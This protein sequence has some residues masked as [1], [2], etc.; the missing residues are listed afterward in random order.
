MKLSKYSNVSVYIAQWKLEVTSLRD[1]SGAEDRCISYTV[2][3]DPHS[4]FQNF[5]EPDINV[6]AF[7]SADNVAGSFSDRLT[8]GKFLHPAD[9][10]E[11]IE[12]VPEFP[13]TLTSGFLR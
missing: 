10:K 8:S 6:M 12:A 3:L 4:C 11:Y 7:H 9:G 5:G 1:P 2:F 13:Y